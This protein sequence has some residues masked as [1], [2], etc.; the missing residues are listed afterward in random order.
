MKLPTKK[1]SKLILLVVFPLVLGLFVVFYLYNRNIDRRVVPP[2]EPQSKADVCAVDFDVTRDEL[3]RKLADSVFGEDYNSPTF[4]KNPIEFYLPSVLRVVGDEIQFTQ[5]PFG[6]GYMYDMILGS[7]L[8]GQY[9]EDLRYLGIYTLSSEYLYENTIQFS[10]EGTYWHLNRDSAC[11]P[12]FFPENMD[13]N[14]FES[15]TKLCTDLYRVDFLN[16]GGYPGS[17]CPM[18]YSSY[19]FV[20]ELAVQ[21]QTNDSAFDLDSTVDQY[22]LEDENHAG[23]AKDFLYL[24]ELGDQSDKCKKDAYFKFIADALYNSINKGSGDG[25]RYF[26]DDLFEILNTVSFGLSRDSL[27][28]EEKDILL[29]V[30]DSVLEVLLDSRVQYTNTYPYGVLE[31]SYMEICLRDSEFFSSLGDSVTLFDIYTT[32]CNYEKVLTT[33]LIQRSC[34]LNGGER[35]LLFSPI[36]TNRNGEKVS[37]AS[38]PYSIRVLSTLILLEES[39][40]FEE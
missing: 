9:L 28:Q 12:L 15:I 1:T 39:D 32:D 16:R 36:S 3:I 21:L 13:E 25:D 8:A 38:L 20:E 18:V 5:P 35:V 37:E 17:Y 14:T 7:F 4:K 2:F 19:T 10:N 34:E 24:Y 31:T 23:K 11:Y 26:K 29:V 22:M 6:V 40:E 30:K 33:S 27:T